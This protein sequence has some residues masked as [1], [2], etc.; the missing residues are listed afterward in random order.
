MHP[1]QRV[2]GV[3]SGMHRM[4]PGAWGHRFRGRPLSGP[5]PISA[6]SYPSKRC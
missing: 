6:V 2:H 3:A 4:H 1:L 5:V